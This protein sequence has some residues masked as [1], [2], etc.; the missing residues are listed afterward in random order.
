MPASRQAHREFGEVTNFAVDRD[1]AAV[2]LGYNLVADRQPKPS[3]LA[4]RLCREERLK[5]FIPVFYRNTDAIVTHPNLDAFAKLA[6]RDLQCWALSAVAPAATL[7]SGVEAIAYKIKE[8]ASQL[9]RHN[10]NGS[11]ITIEVAL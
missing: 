8:H 7:V 3:A 2:L 11:E 1:G 9:L 10:V 4:G 6:G 5:Q